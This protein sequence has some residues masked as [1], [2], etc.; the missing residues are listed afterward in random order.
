MVP[1]EHVLIDPLYFQ[2]RGMKYIGNIGPGVILWRVKL[3]SI[4][5]NSN[6][7]TA[8]Y[9]LDIYWYLSSLGGRELHLIFVSLCH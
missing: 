5:I 7:V 2:N 4:I 6:L 3:A 1:K 8:F 9:I